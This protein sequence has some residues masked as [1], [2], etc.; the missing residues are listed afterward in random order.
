MLS[1]ETTIG[2]FPVKAVQT[3]VAIVAYHEQFV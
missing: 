2:K 3:Q 1:E